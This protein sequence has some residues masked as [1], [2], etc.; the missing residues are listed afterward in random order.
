MSYIH[1]IGCKD[2]GISKL[3]LIPNTQF[4]WIVRLSVWHSARKVER[5]HAKNI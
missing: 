1:N 3:K 4:L 2:I 5:S